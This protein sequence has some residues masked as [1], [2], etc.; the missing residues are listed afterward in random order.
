[1]CDLAGSEYFEFGAKLM[2][3]VCCGEL[4]RG[5]HIREKSG[6]Y[7]EHSVWRDKLDA[8][9][10]IYFRTEDTEIFTRLKSSNLADVYRTIDSI[11]KRKS[12]EIGCIIDWKKM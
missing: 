5:F 8:Q 7:S 2:R 6:G 10:Y 4:L 9:S 3:D 1:M 11:Y 12:S